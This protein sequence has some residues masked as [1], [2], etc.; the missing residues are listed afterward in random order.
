[1]V[2]DCSAYVLSVVKGPN[3]VDR[4]AL[5]FLGDALESTHQ[6]DKKLDREASERLMEMMLTAG[7]NKE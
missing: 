4:D 3:S 2:D 6:P 7:K 1:M 5:T